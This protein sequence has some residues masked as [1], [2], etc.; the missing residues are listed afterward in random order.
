MID[1]EALTL[2]S[3][4]RPLSM[5]AL[6]RIAAASERR[7]HEQGEVIFREGDIAAEFFM[8][9]HGH[10]ALEM[11]VGGSRRAMVH[12]ISPGDFFGWSA[13][14]PPQRMTA[15][16]RAVEPSTVIAIPDE[17]FEEVFRTEPAAGLQVMREVSRIISLRLKDT[18]LQLINLM[19]WPGTGNA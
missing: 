18:S 6:A 11:E 10:V 13:L 9:E 14:V 4:L 7:M 16:A 15:S 1:T 17:V 2:G 12:T 5:E 8:L 3:L 19:E